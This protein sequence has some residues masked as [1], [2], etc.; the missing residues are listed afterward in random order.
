MVSPL[1]VLKVKIHIF[2]SSIFSPKF[3]ETPI[4]IFLPVKV[5]RKKHN[6]CRRCFTDDAKNKNVTLK[7]ES[8]DLQCSQLAFFS[9]QESE[10]N[11]YYSCPKRGVG[12]FCLHYH[13][14]R[15]EA[16]DAQEILGNYCQ[17]CNFRHPV[18]Y[19]IRS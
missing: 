13:E 4:E 1:L 8:D 6:Y 17:W 12:V 15:D 5:S 19:I 7:T 2:F 9:L 16:L 10:L 3:F 18:A 11:N 14:T